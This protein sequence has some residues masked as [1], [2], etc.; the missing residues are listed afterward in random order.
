MSFG[1]IRKPSIGVS[2]SSPTENGPLG[3]ESPGGTNSFIHSFIME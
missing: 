2:D 3:L 1:E